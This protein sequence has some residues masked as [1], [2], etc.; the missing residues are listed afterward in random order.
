MSVLERLH[1]SLHDAEFTL[2]DVEFAPRRLVRTAYQDIDFTTQLTKNTQLKLPLMS[3]PMDTVTGAEMAI[4]MARMG[5]IGVIHLNF[6]TIEDQMKEVEKVRRYQAGFVR[7]PV[8][9]G[10]GSTLADIRELEAHYPFRS[11]PVTQDGTMDTPLIGLVT[12]KDTEL[13][14]RPEDGE[15]KVR[16][17]MTPKRKLI[18]GRAEE[19]TER[20]DIRAANTLIRDKKLDTLPIVDAD[21]K[22]VAMVTRSDIKKNQQNP[23]ATM[24]GNKQLK[25]YIAVDSLPEAAFPRIDAAVAAGVSGIVID[26]R[27]M[28]L[29][30]LEQARYAKSLNPE[31]DVIVGNFGD[32]LAV[33]EAMELG[34]DVIDAVR[35]GVG[36]GGVCSTTE[37]TGM[38]RPQGSN[39]RDIGY[40]LATNWIPKLGF[41]GLISDGGSNNSRHITVNLGLGADAVMMGSWLGGLEESPSIARWEEGIGRYSKTVRGMGS[42]QVIMERYAGSDS[43]YGL[44]G[45]PPEERFAEGI[46]KSVPYKGPGERHIKHLFDG[47]RTAFQ[48]M[49]AANIAELREKIYFRPALTAPTKGL[50]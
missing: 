32:A 10:R 5:G 45:I 28:Y 46:S 41:K 9:V 43:R 11:F 29:S 23:N 38:G 8:V 31:M 42:A 40:E 25:V 19:T 35:D 26:A 27:N 37:N 33:R 48:G 4:L 30:N 44:Y 36:T 22:L 47:V 2:D 6:P 12:Q 1:P 15:R 24:D 7:N 17:L 3:S 50:S 16:D 34:G 20:D 18:T 21:G 49:D 39:V 14:D 13:Y